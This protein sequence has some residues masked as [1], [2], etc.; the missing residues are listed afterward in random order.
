LTDFADEHP[1]GPESITELAGQDG[2]EEFQAVH[3]QNILEDFDPIGK[4]AS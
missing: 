3:G 1:A 4:F 2:T